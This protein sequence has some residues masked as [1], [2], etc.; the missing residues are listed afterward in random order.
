MPEKDRFHRGVEY[1]S[2]EG[3]EG[4]PAPEEAHSIQSCPQLTK[5]DAS[6]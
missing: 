5:R 2:E 1:T 6:L 3:K 4:D